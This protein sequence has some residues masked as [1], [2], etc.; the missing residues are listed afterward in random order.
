[1]SKYTTNL[2]LFEYDTSTDGAQVFSIDDAINENF[3]K[4][5]NFAGE[6]AAFQNEAQNS[7]ATINTNLG[8]KLE[9]QVL[10]AENGYIKFNNRILIQ[11]GKM[12]NSVTVTLPTAYS[13]TIYS[14]VTQSLQGY[15]SNR[16]ANS[17]VT[18]KSTTTFYFEST[19]AEK[20]FNFISIGY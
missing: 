13:N 18:S 20:S 12:S 2:N 14:V 9:A 4:I 8:K 5:D 15:S 7:L 17:A 16:T 3:D 11:F 6:M 10:L 19:S 1:M